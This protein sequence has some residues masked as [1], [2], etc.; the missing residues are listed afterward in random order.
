MKTS[1][2]SFIKPILCPESFSK[3]PQDGGQCINYAQICQLHGKKSAGEGKKKNLRQFRKWSLA[4][5]WI[6]KVS[7][8]FSDYQRISFP[9][10]NNKPSSIRFS[11]FI[12]NSIQWQLSFCP[13]WT[14]IFPSHYG[15]NERKVVFMFLRIAVILF[16]YR[17]WYAISSH[18]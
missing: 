4:P 15:L 14:L 7:L 18:L 12:D 8:Y 3:W 13:F 10:Y 6:E 16:F 1:K 17:K 9:Y 2:L 11:S 5:Y